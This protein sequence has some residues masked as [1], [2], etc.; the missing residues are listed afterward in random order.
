VCVAGGAVASVIGLDFLVRWRGMA[1]RLRA[2]GTGG[3]VWRETFKPQRGAIPA[4][5]LTETSQK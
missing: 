1:A 5:M 4:K 2:P 3:K